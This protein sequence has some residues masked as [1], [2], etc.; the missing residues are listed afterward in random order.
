M[1]AT[2]T[3]RQHPLVTIETTS[4]S[5]ISGFL[6]VPVPP[7][8]R[9]LS[10][11]SLQAIPRHHH[12]LGLAFADQQSFS[13]FYPVADCTLADFIANTSPTDKAG[14]YA[15]PQDLTDDV[16]RSCMAGL[17]FLHGAGLVMVDVPML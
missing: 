11:F 12:L 5:Y 13:L 7:V 14:E 16:M 4:S 17:A 2:D 8:L 9:F 3:V 6:S 1:Y 10:V 15:S